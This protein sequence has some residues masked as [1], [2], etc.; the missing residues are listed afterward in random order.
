[1]RLCYSVPFWTSVNPISLSSHCLHSAKPTH[2]CLYV[3]HQSPVPTVIDGGRRGAGRVRLIREHDVGR[4][5]MII[6]D[7]AL[8]SPLGLRMVH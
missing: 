1:M 3:T 5:P 4:A 8:Y 2:R 6:T 7:W